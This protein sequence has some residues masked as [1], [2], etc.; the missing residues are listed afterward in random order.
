ML[1]ETILTIEAKPCRIKRNCTW[2]TRW[3][4][5]D[6]L[7]YTGADTVPVGD[8][9]LYDFGGAVAKHLVDTI[10]TEKVT[11]L[12][13]DRY[14]TGLAILD[15]LVSRNVYLTGTVMTNRT[16]GV[17]ESFPKDTCMERGSLVS[18]RRED[19][20]ACLVKWKDKTSVLLL[21]SAFGIKPDGS[22]K[23]W[24][25]EQR[26]REDV[27]QPAIVRSYNTHTNLILLDIHTDQEMNNACLC[28][29]FEYGHLH[30]AWIMYIR[31]CKECKVPLSNRLH[32]I[33]FKLVIAES[34]IKAEVF[35]E[36]VQERPQRKQNQQIVPL[37][38][39]DVRYDGIGHFPEHVKRE[40]Q[41][42]CRFPGGPGKSRVRCIKCDL[43]L[44][45]QKRNC[46][47]EFHNK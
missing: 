40:N 38:V 46:F 37:P 9:Q 26:Q 36:A 10:P 28:T 8:K 27:R 31:H 23:R 7:I 6:F 30:N 16:D 41:M 12:F 47:F 42:K 39:N 4:C 35:E 33:D 11:H 24:S 21:S 29:F 13:T 34:L 32:L 45:L 43:Y 19:R 17:T 15:Y 44:Y 22:C 25:K 1:Y 2:C 14:F 18:R 20:K 3:A 5:L